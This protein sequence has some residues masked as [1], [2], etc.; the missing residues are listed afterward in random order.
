MENKFEF[1]I[2]ILLTVAITLSVV[3][4]ISSIV[5]RMPQEMTVRFDQKQIA[6]SANCKR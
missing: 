2:V 3:S 6:I 4:I 5:I 1:P